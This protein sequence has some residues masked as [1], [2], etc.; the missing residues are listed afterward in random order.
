M[1]INN[2]IDKLKEIKYHSNKMVMY[3]SDFFQ[4][5]TTK[6]FRPLLLVFITGGGV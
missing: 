1:K 4:L 2:T 6:F 5:S 3:L